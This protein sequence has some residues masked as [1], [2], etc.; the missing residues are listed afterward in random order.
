MRQLIVENFGPVANAKIEIRKF[1]LFIGEQSIGKSILAKLITIFTDYL[2]LWLFKVNGEK[3]WNEVLKAYD[4]GVYAKGEY[5]INYTERINGINV[6]IKISPIAKDCRMTNDQNMDITVGDAF[7]KML[8]AKPWF[9]D[10]TMKALEALEAKEENFPEF[11]SYIRNSLYIPAERIIA[12]QVNRLLPIITMG[13][14]QM[15]MNL[16]RYLSELNNAKAA[17]SDLK[18]DL[19]NVAYSKKEDEDWIVLEDK[20]EIPLKIASSGIQSTLPLLLVFNYGV[21]KK[22][23][24]SFV[25]EEPECNLFPQKQVE[26]LQEL[27]RKTYPDDRILTI[28]THS[29]YLLSAINNYLYAG[30]LARE[31]PEQK[32][33]ELR[34]LIRDDMWLDINDCAIYSLGKKINKG[35]YSLNLVDPDSGLIDFNYLDGVS[36]TMGEEFSKLNHMYVLQQRAQRNK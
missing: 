11:I 14:E 18:L 31:I 6:S 7:L 32:K 29:P 23:Y 10:S 26:L 24:A 3:A 2:N 15:P 36:L 13:K 5:S 35:E 12:A 27:I 21:E 33:E 28:T 4:L 34:S 22:E 30:R 25:V 17:F 8:E 20:S 16:L 19:L 9:H 1:N